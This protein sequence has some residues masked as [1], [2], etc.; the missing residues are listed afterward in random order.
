MKKKKEV[1]HA[2]EFVREIEE[3]LATASDVHEKA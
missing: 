1:D 3:W 2:A